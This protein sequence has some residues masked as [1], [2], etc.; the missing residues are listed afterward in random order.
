MSLQTTPRD[1]RAPV[2]F[3]QGLEKLGWV[4]GRNVRI[5]T[6]WAAGRL[7]NFRKYAQELVALESEVI[8]GT[9]TPAVIAL[10]QASRSVPIVFVSVVDPVGSG[11]VASMSRPGGNA[12]G[13]V[14][15]EYS[16]AGKWLELLKEIA[17]EI[18]RAAVL[19]DSSYAAGIG[20]FAAIQ[21][22]GPIELDLNVIDLGSTEIE[23][24]I[25]EFAHGTK[26]GLI[27]T[28]CQF[29]A[30]HPDV[31]AAIA[32]RHKLPAVYPFRYFV[33]AGGLICYG[34]DP[35]SEYPRGG[36]LC[37]PH[38]QRS[39]TNRSPCTGADQVCAGHQ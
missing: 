38:L 24:D 26:G 27:V 13:F 4:A 19:R 2:A 30:N 39:E 6:R 17:P 16:L 33:T 21:A 10:Q 23:R 5:D 32:A 31:I 36:G 7:D 25:A 11:L 15:F 12:T 28:A 34:P 35:N 14:I 18:K 1:K 9:T 29:G 22:A 8:V 20:Q 3:L 37:R